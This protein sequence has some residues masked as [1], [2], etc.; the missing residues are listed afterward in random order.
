MSIEWRSLI[1]H[2]LLTF[3]AL[4]VAGVSLLALA[5]AAPAVAD[6][7]VWSVRSIVAP[8][9]LSST[10]G[11]GLAVAADEV[12]EIKVLAATTEF[13]VYEPVAIG[14]GELFNEKGEPEFAELPFNTTALKLEEELQKLYGAG[15][16]KVT[17]DP[18]EYTITFT[19]EL[20]DQRVGLIGTEG[21]TVTQVTSGQSA[22]NGEVIVTVTNLG[23]ITA[24]ASSADP[25]EISTRLPAGVTAISIS[26]PEGLGS[27]HRLSMICKLA[28][29]TCAGTGGGSGGQEAGKVLPYESVEI[30][31]PVLVAKNARSGPVRMSVSGGGAAPVSV[32]DPL[33]VSEAPTKFGME[34][35]EMLPLNADGSLD[36]QAGSHPFQF[37]TTLAFNQGVAEQV[38]NEGSTQELVPLP[39]ALPKDLMFNLPPGLIGDPAAVPQCPLGEFQVTDELASQCPPDTQVGVVSSVLSTYGSPSQGQSVLQP[40][41]TVAPVYNLEPSVG[42]PA[43]FGFIAPALG[44]AVSV[45]LDTSLR[46]GGDYGVVVSVHNINQEVFFVGSQLSFW[47]DPG[48]PRH[49]L[50]RG[51]ECLE[52]GEFVAGT[53]CEEGPALKQAPFLTLPASCSGLS[54]PFTA[55]M[56]ATSWGQPT[57]PVSSTYVLHENGGEPLGL[58]GCNRLPFDASI[59][60]AP[61]SQNGSTPTG[62][63]V[64]V[65]VLQS[66][67]LNPTGLTEAD[68][69]NTTV[70]LPAGVQLSPS[71]SDGLLACSDAQ[72]GFT[73]VNPLTGTD[74]FT[75]ARPSCPDASKIATV[76]IKTPLLPNALEGAVY[77]AAPQN[78]AGPLENP[79]GSL[80]AMY[81]V[82]EDP[83]SGV[84]V[85]LP[86]KVVPNPE[87]G[88]LVSTFEDT[89]Q[90]PFEELELHF[91]G[92]A[93]APLSTPAVCGTYTTQM[94]STPWSGNPPVMSS[95][96]F[97][98]TAGPNGVP[99]SDPQ[100]FTPGFQAGSTNL[101][102]GAFTPFTLTMTRPDA[103]QT[104][105]RIEMQ[106]PPG[107]SGTL[108]GVKLCGEPQAQEGRC[109]PES[110]IGET[111]VSAGLGGDPYTVT[112]GKVYITTGYNG[113]PYGLSIVNPAA[114]GPFVL[115]EGRPVVVR[116]SIYVDPHTAALRIVSDPLPTILDGI[117]LQIQH[118]NV[119]VDREKFTFNPTDCNKM[120]IDG[121]LASSEGATAAVSTPFQ[122]TNCASLTFAPK[123]AVSTSGKTSRANGA[124]L[125]VKLTYP[126]GPQG[127]EAN[128][129]KVK[130][131]LPKRLPSRLTTLQKACPSAQFEANPAGC[132]AA[133]IV[134][135][136]KA[137]TPILP[138]PLE[139]PAY[140]VSHGG[141]AFPSLIVVLQGYG[142]TVDLVG[143]T[144]ISKAGITSSTFKTVPDVPVGSFELKLPQGK[145]SAL[146]A[147]GNLCDG[148]LEMP[149]EFVAQNGAEIHESTKISVTG[150]PKQAKRATHRKKA[151]GKHR[152]KK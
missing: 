87:T 42:E 132:P 118:V 117:P 39:L 152:R 120:A 135:H 8:T 72:I 94:S 84:L 17:G 91:F 89:P 26:E 45:F 59:T 99:C 64:G 140:F 74:E 147:N 78:F 23:D 63:T 101:Q 134:G 10:S 119:T 103:D 104:L 1:A 80:V 38:A 2:P 137:S 138:V 125:A 151:K 5:G 121:K 9:N 150:C 61:D 73:G 95:S 35:F 11:S 92:S 82:A 114:A 40:F 116:A 57:V 105:G 149:T 124:S 52:V 25:V 141:E 34:R 79:F 115:N 133:S 102:A 88:Q 93:R 29:L 12:Q 128:I 66:P 127:S 47:G 111:V 49:D 16:V 136:A 22:P 65:R 143:S 28:S 77:L 48:D 69:K 112:G 126:N 144:F 54:D 70:A 18:G 58:T 67:A 107:L 122:V 97:E 36:T 98:I 86:G 106:M 96:S 76:K 4:V 33:T 41:I 71:A 32:S 85:K 37:T 55:T 31:I 60:A 30:V 75:S 27:G 14:K 109:G 7:P 130:V 15:N 123:F 146:A 68:V 131:E 21:A 83:V 145:Y 46:T 19:G 6:V 108:S 20:A 50:A 148:S 44:P 142:T 53:E 51:A 129:A 113:A 62:L 139:G 13:V 3:G 56:E 43:R 100:P 110:L 24:T 90:L 81:I